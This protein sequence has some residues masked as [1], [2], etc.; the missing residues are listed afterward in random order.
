MTG[1]PA[2][3][4]SRIALVLRAQG[5]EPDAEDVDRALRLLAVTLTAEQAYAEVDAEFGD[6]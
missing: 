2:D 1:P 4:A 6:V 3:R 5:P